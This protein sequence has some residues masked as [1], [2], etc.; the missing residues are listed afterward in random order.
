MIGRERRAAEATG[1]PRNP[2]TE[3]RPRLCRGQALLLRS[4]STSPHHGQVR[5]EIP[6]FRILQFR[7]K[8]GSGQR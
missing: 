4:G 7:L 3:R 1:R 5:P 2:E 6:A 8:S